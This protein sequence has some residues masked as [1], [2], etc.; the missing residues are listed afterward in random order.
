MELQKP[1]EPSAAVG[2]QSHFMNEP[3]SPLQ[4]GRQWRLCVEGGWCHIVAVQ[5]VGVH[6]AE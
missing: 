3:H 2:E 4:V 1:S 6:A 5:H